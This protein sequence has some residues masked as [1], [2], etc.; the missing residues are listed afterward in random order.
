[1]AWHAASGF[2]LEAVKD[3]A[4]KIKRREKQVE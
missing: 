4:A 2:A 1:M 3:P